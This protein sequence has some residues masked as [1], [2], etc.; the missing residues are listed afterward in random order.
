M[1][2][3][4]CW[5]DSEVS[6][7][8]PYPAPDQWTWVMSCCSWLYFFIPLSIK[9]IQLLNSSSILFTSLYITGFLVP[10]STFN[11]SEPG[12]WLLPRKQL[13]I[14]SST[15]LSF[16]S[17]LLFGESVPYNCCCSLTLISQFC[18]ATRIIHW[19]PSVPSRWY[20]LLS[21]PVKYGH[22]ASFFFF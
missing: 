2:R 7:C 11:L 18:S 10:H 14:S 17:F 21:S 15:L 3:S 13:C 9:H 20:H 22:S 5:L 19:I 6:Q 1:F 8:I 4:N 12:I 16:W